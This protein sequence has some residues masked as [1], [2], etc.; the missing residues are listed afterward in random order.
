MRKRKRVLLFLLGASF[1][2]NASNVCA[3]DGKLWFENEAEV[4]AEL[5]KSK[6]QA[7]EMQN[8]KK[9]EVKVGFDVPYFQNT[10]IQGSS[11]DW[12]DL[13]EIRLLDE[14]GNVVGTENFDFESEYPD[15]DVNVVGKKTYTME[16]NGFTTEFE[17][18]VRPCEFQ[19][20][21]GRNE[22]GSVDIDNTG[23]Y[24]RIPIGG[25]I[26]KAN[27]VTCTRDAEVPEQGYGA[28]PSFPFDSIVGK[29][30][31]ELFD[32]T[33]V[34]IYEIPV[35]IK[36]ENGVATGI[37]K[38]MVGIPE[39]GLIDEM[40]P[41]DAKNNLPDKDVVGAWNI[42]SGEEGVGTW[43]FDTGLTKDSGVTVWSYHNAQWLKIGEYWVDEEGNATVTLTEDQTSP[44]LITKNNLHK[45]A[46][47]N[48][49]DENDS[50]INGT[51]NSS[52]TNTNVQIK[53]K[54]PKTGDS[55]N[56]QPSF[57]ACALSIFAV[58][59]IGIRKKYSK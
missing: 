14:N 16:Y 7:G 26:R 27:I 23:K 25:D 34:G 22:D 9:I 48:S 52:K 35:T 37:I 36:E 31:E 19:I 54:A 57:L 24:I 59:V 47:D 55:N 51:D 5:G 45:P 39:K 50:K 3:S 56:V 12:Y 13:G 10:I 42:P 2:L 15:F 53:A 40:L 41:S 20:I 17:I 30:I 46:K 4:Q 43:V 58:M 49:K 33:K 6:L 28:E 8:V 44:I 32:N 1:V 18:N 29:P 38:L 11:S 21:V